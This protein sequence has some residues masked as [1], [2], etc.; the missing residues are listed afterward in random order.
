MIAAIFTPG[1]SLSRCI[2]VDLSRYD[3]TWAVNTGIRLV[4]TD[5]LAAG[6]P[7][8]VKGSIGEHRPRLGL[9][10]MGT[11]AEVIVGCPTW[12]D[13]KVVT[14]NDVPLIAEHE[15]RGK[16]V[17]WSI[18]TALA[19]ACHLGARRIDLYGCDI[20]RADF[21]PWQ[22]ADASGYGGE[23]R[24][25]TRWDRER[26]DLQHTFSILADHGTTV[27]RIDL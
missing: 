4:K 24:N 15:E 5:W 9:L 16:A 25:R 23:D 13:I 11:T 2:G 14:W 21:D 1:P 17:S 3:V 26:E 8:T 22:V 10:T 19:H 6:D 12:G 27:Q 18:Q 20:F 7:A